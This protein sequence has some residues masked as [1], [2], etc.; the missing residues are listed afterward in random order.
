MSY[1][2]GYWLPATEEVF[3]VIRGSLP[4]GCELVT[5]GGGRLLEQVA[6]NL[7]FLIAGKVAAE[8]VGRASRLK[9]IMSPGAGTDGISLEAAAAAGIPV[10]AT[11]CGN[12]DE[13]AEHTILLMLAVSRKLPELDASIRAG[14]WLMWSRR[15]ESH[16][17]AGKALG[18]VGLGRIGTAVARRA[19]AFGMGVSYFDCVHRPGYTYMELDELLATSD[20]VSLHV[21][22][23]PATRAL[24]NA[25]RMAAMKQ[26][27]VLINTAR[28]EVVDEKALAAAL[29][30]GRL[31]GA[32]LDVFESEPPSASNPLLAMPNVVLTPHVASGTVDSL[33]RK[34][35]QYAENIRRILDGVEPIDCVVGFGNR[36][37]PAVQSNLLRG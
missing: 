37:E 31:G 18:I 24:V 7:D 10:A 13:V 33:R 30:E 27:A 36:G 15:L 22:L 34:A 32:G 11:V 4:A 16:T 21:P 28:G 25:E 1:C 23:T 6:P 35:A 29:C 8:V 5:P 9:L 2:V 12:I 19:Q 14:S 26:G 3:D 17:L 20:Y